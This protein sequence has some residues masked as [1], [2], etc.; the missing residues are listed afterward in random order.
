MY[1]EALAEDVADDDIEEDR[2]ERTIRLFSL[3]PAVGAVCQLLGA[4]V[5]ITA[6]WTWKDS[7]APDA[8]PIIELRLVGF[9]YFFWSLSYICQNRGAFELPGG[10][11]G[12][13]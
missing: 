11:A 7:G 6:V 12:E 5:T 13:G 3:T 4:I 2:A 10:Q 8:A 1:A 9:C